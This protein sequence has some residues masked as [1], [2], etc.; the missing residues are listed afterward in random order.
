MFGKVL[1]VRVV[2]P[3]ALACQRERL[4]IG[5]AIGQVGHDEPVEVVQHLLL[6]RRRLG[7]HHQVEAV[8]G[9]DALVVR[10]AGVADRLEVALRS[11]R[12]VL[13]LDRDQRQRVA[14]EHRA[15]LL[16]E[17]H[18]GQRIG[19]DRFGRVFR[20]VLPGEGRAKRHRLQ[21]GRIVDRALARIVEPLSAR[22]DQDRIE[23]DHRP[24]GRMHRELEALALE[25]R[26]FLDGQPLGDLAE[27]VPGTRR[28][29]VRI[30][31]DFLEVPR[32]D[33][34]A[35]PVEPDR[36]AVDLAIGYRTL[37]ERRREVVDERL[38][39]G[40]AEL[41]HVQRRQ[42]ALGHPGRHEPIL[43]DE[44]VRR[45]AGREADADL[46]AEVT[47]G[48]PLEV[49]LHVRILLLVEL[50]ALLDPG[51][52]LRILEGPEADVDRRLALRERPARHGAGRERAQSRGAKAADD[53]APCQGRG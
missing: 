47:E 20:A 23:L 34:V 21:A 50:H 15:P 2:D 39:V 16:Q 26:A 44:P 30:E 24:L 3:A 53:V 19:R 4:R 41:L 17:I 49:D 9:G 22:H 51:P 10:H 52:L 36:V 27:L 25:A 1:H 31:A 13:R 11:R 43:A 29:A 28:V 5:P 48:E 37:H 12:L 8:R 18:A 35:E 42:Q 14:P 45:G 32:V 38:V 46:L 40:V 33:V 7:V 6:G